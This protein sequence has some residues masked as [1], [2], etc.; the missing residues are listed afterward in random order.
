[1]EIE[2]ITTLAAALPDGSFYAGLGSLVIVGEAT[3]AVLMAV[4]R[5]FPVAAVVAV[6]F[7]IGMLIFTQGRISW[8]FAY[9]CGAALLAL[10]PWPEPLRRPSWPWL[11]AQLPRFVERLL[12][13]GSHNCD[14]APATPPWRW[15]L[16]YFGLVVF[17]FAA[18][19]IWRI[20][21]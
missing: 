20:P 13:P 18:R 14:D 2:W 15:P 3:L 11:D 9:A 19:R 5:W 10:W 1:M 12:L 17:F 21:G 4:P 6:S 8:V 7:H 16:L